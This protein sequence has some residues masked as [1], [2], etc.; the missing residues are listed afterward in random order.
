MT[1]NQYKKN[2]AHQLRILNERIDYKILH[3]QRYSEESRQHRE[4][5]RQ[6][7]K[8]SKRGFFSRMIPSL[9]QFQ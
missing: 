2:I 9:F 6:M 5:R 3:G 8:Q 4:L 1:Q 7:L